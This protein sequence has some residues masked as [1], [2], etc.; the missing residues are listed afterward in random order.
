MGVHPVAALVAVEAAAAS[1][2]SPELPG[3]GLKIGSLV[4]AD[5]SAGVLPV[6]KGDKGVVLKVINF[7][8]YGDSES[9]NVYECFIASQQVMCGT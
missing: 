7:D 5:S 9:K 6:P 1:M 8:L 2:S 4:G 3:I